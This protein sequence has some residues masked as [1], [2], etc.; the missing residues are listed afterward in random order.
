MN[1]QKD[2]GDYFNL[3]TIKKTTWYNFEDTSTT[4]ISIVSRCC[5]L[6]APQILKGGSINY[7]R[8]NN[9]IS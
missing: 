2:F 4:M 5:V 1:A 6:T 8:T 3:V 9:K 7:R